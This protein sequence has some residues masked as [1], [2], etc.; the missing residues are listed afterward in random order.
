LIYKKIHRQAVSRLRERHAEAGFRT[1]S[2]LFG[3]TRQAYYKQVKSNVKY[4][5]EEAI[6]LD[7]VKSYRKEMPRIGGSKLHN[8]INKSGNKNVQHA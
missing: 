8:L 4:R 7:M 5:L 2:S 6:V 3:Y 1:L